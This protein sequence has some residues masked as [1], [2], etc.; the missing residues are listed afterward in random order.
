MT[1]NGRCRICRFEIFKI[2]KPLL[3]FDYFL[4]KKCIIFILLFFI[5]FLPTNY[6]DVVFC[7]INLH[8]TQIKLFFE[9]RFRKDFKVVTLLRQPTPEN[10]QSGQ[11]F[12]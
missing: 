11:G 2:N 10:M 4:S 1:N 12:L 8:F 5:L 7:E 6:T 9:A 3:I